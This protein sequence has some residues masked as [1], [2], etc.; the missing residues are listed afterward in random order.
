MGKMSCLGGNVF[1]VGRVSGGGD[2]YRYW[3]LPSLSP[4]AGM[5]VR[6]WGTM[7]DR[8]AGGMFCARST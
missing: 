7:A 3:T 5:K 6:W 8:A 1:A 2:V 4:A